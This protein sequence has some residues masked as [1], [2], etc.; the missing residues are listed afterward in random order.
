M[1]ASAFDYVRASSISEALDHLSRHGDAAKIVAGGQSLIPALNLRLLAPEILIDIA[2]IDSLR[3][4]AVENGSVRIGAL[5]RHADIARSAEIAEKAPL[6]SAAIRHVAHPAI[7]NR[8]TLGGN[9]AHADPASELPACMLA[10]DAKIVIAGPT[11]ERHVRAADFFRGIYET[12]LEPDELIVAVEL[13]AATDGQVSYFEEIA[14]RS[15]DYAI[16]GLA[17][18]GR[19]SSGTIDHLRLGY[20]AVGSRAT[21]ATAAADRIAGRAV[22]QDVVAEAQTALADDLD[23]QDDQ[24]ASA[25]MRLHLARTLLG[26]CL[27]ALTDSSNTKGSDAP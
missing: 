15:G 20:F 23:P 6:L 7:R 27:A 12:A 11:G 26:R 24:Q 2:H 19:V 21:L 14:R 17:A 9:L 5:T 22:T 4:I 1:K 25:D 18:Q 8:G 13:A 10:L 16:V 3:Y